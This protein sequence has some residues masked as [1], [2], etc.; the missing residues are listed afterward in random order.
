[1][2]PTYGTAQPPTMVPSPPTDKYPD[3]PW[4]ADIAKLLGIQ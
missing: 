1:M 4:Y 3:E 2:A